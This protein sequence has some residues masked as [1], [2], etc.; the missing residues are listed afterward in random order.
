MKNRIT[1]LILCLMSN[2]AFAQ[3][4]VLNETTPP[5]VDPSF[6]LSVSLFLISMIGVSI[7]LDHF[8][9]HYNEML[10]LWILSGFVFA[11]GISILPTMINGYLFS[12]VLPNWSSLKLFTISFAGHLTWCLILLFREEGEEYRRKIWSVLDPFER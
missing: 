7:L 1:V 5:T 6:G 8:K 2:F 3:Q 9:I 10:G 4:V 11:V 12:P